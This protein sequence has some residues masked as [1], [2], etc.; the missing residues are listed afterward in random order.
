VP[1]C[2]KY[3]RLLPIAVAD[4]QL[5]FPITRLLGHSGVECGLREPTSASIGRDRAHNYWLDPAGTGLLAV[6]L[7][8]G[9]AIGR[10]S[11]NPPIAAASARRRV[12]KV[13]LKCFPTARLAQRKRRMGSRPGAA[14]GVVFD[15]PITFLM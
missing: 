6:D 2:F 4:Q 14:G 3:F 8:I 7:L 15:V 12:S 9:M 1:W 10:L 11:E 5:G 13:R